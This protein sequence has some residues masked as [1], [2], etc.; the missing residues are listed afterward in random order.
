[1][2]ILI[3]EIWETPLNSPFSRENPRGTKFY[4]A[5]PR[6]LPP[7]IGFGGNFGSFFG[8]FSGFFWGGI[9]ALNGH[10]DKTT[11]TEEG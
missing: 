9:S 7:E 3:R 11:P 6:F 10:P 2:G 8:G 1:M 5:P 4:R